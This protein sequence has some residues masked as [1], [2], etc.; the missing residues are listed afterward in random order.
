MSRP[1]SGLVVGALALCAAAGFAV[2]AFGFGEAHA[3]ATKQQV[4]TVT[5]TATEFK[6]ALSKKRVPTGQVI[7][8]LVNKGK[9]GHN[10]AIAGKKTPIVGPHKTATLKVVFTKKGTFAYSC[11]VPGHAR[12]GMKGKLAVGVKALPPPPAT[13]TTTATTYP[14]PG[15]TVHVSMFEYGFTL[16]PS[17]VPSG[18]VTFVV[19]NDG[20]IVHNFEVE[21][22]NPRG[23]FLQ[24]GQSE[25]ITLNL[26]AGHTYKYVC[27]VPE[28]EGD[29][30][31]GTF[32]P[33]P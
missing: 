11:T 27:D 31:E 7:F 20:S 2:A 1:R 4:T 3:A 18:N 28:H 16:T 32:T 30:M 12:L 21:G 29:G 8:K 26:Q 9:I 24:P 17:T 15:G 23:S 10:F 25:S 14:G 5:V 33:T 19:K 22:V 6:F 13:T